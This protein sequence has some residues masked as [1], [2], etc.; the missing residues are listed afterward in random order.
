MLRDIHYQ[1]VADYRRSPVPVVASP[2]FGKNFLWSYEIGD[3]SGEI[4][5]GE[6]LDFRVDDVFAAGVR[7]HYERT[8]GC[9]RRGGC[10]LVFQYVT[11]ENLRFRFI[12]RRFGQVESRRPRNPRQKDDEN[13]PLMT[14]EDVVKVAE[15]QR[16]WLSLDRAR[17]HIDWLFHASFQ[18]HPCGFPQLIRP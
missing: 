15:I 14:E 17:L 7:R 10:A 9:A 18:P 8:A 2:H 13:H 16:R 6:D 12:N 5:A 4:K 1:A 3:L 11:N